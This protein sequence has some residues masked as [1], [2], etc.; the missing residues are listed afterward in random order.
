[1]HYFGELLSGFLDARAKKKVW[2]MGCFYI[3]SRA[4]LPSQAGV[5]NEKSHKIEAYP[6]RDQV[7]V[8]LTAS[9]KKSTFLLKSRFSGELMYRSVDKIVKS[10]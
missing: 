7:P 4:L 10:L 3:L 6:L 8:Y 9:F 1:V 2:T 5:T